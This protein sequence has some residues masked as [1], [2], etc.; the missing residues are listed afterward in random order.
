MNH[1]ISEVI[2]KDI[3]SCLTDK[4]E[5]EDVSHVQGDNYHI[6]SDVYYYF[7]R[8]F[9]KHMLTANNSNRNIGSIVM[10][11][12]PFTFGHRYLIEY[13]A[14]IVDKL[15]IFVVEEDKSFFRFEDRMK[16]VVSGTKDI[17]NICV[18]PS[19]K[20]IISQATFSQYFEKENISY[21]KSMDYDVRIFA[22]I[23]A[24]YLGI[25]CRF[26]GEE[27]QDYVTKQYNC[28]L[29]RILPEY[30]IDLVEIPRKTLADGEV[31]S[32]TTVRKLLKD[33]N[34]EKL[35]QYCPKTTLDILKEIQV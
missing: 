4:N 27:I 21:V 30:K 15:Y 24:P 29:K 31:I 16:M 18:L 8:Y 5:S 13:A 34:F 1:A 25:G 7:G 20:Y 2:Y 22:E 3:Q 11:C 17:P 28:T 19:G 6:S 35:C 14:S 10:N 12:N 9:D 33:G 23:V 32:A 26:V